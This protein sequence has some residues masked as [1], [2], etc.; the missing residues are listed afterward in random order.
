MIVVI[1]V[2]AVFVFTGFRY[3]HFFNYCIHRF[4]RKAFPECNKQTWI[5]WLF[6]GVFHKSDK[7][8]HIWILSDLFNQLAIRATKLSLNI[9]GAKC[10]V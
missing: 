4:F 1:I 7:V 9:Q 6:V 8:L 2:I 5:K 10:K 3:K